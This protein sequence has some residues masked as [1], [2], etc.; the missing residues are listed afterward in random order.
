M[1]LPWQ[2]HTRIAVVGDVMLDE[3]LDGEVHRISPEAPVP[4]VHVKKEFLVLGGAG[5]S[6]A[7]ISALGGTA[8]L[9]SVLGDDQTGADITKLVHSHDYMNPIFVVAPERITTRKTR[10]T[11]HTHQICRVD[12]ETTEPLSNKLQ[13]ELF[14]KF[15]QLFADPKL[16]PD[17]VLLSDYAKGVLSPDICQELIEVAKSYET[18]VI[19]DP[20]GQDY[21]KYCG[22]TLIT[23]NR[24]EACEALKVDPHSKVTGEKLGEQLC[25][26]LDF[27]NVLVTLGDEGMVLVQRGKQ[28]IHLPAVAREVYDV[29][30]AGDTVAAVMALGLGSNCT[31]EYSMQLANRAAAI[32]VSKTGT[33]PIKDLELLQALEAEEK[34]SPWSRFKSFFR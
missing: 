29:S 34:A 7:N 20:K 1:L 14:L 25:D 28:S 6:A 15:E 13:M 10:I 17:A 30:G 21:L 11:S 27:D 4:V 32:A 9:I 31:L 33:Q 3:Y 22:A 19:V 18:P 24:K 2:K 26:L 8:T 5:N 16:R 23:P 12:R